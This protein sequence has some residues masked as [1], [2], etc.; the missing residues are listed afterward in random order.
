MNNDP[1]R[2]AGDTWK[3]IP[4]ARRANT[5]AEQED[6]MTALGRP[7]EPEAPTR[8]Y[9]TWRSVGTAAALL[10]VGT[11]VATYRQIERTASVVEVIPPPNGQVY[12]EEAVSSNTRI[13]SFNTHGHAERIVGRYL[14][15][16]EKEHVTV[17]LMQEVKPSDKLSRRN[18]YTV[19]VTA[20]PLQHGGQGIAA[21]VY[22][23]RPTDAKQVVFDGTD[24]VESAIGMLEGAISPIRSTSD[25][26][27]EKR[28]VMAFTIKG[29]FYN[30][31][32]KKFEV[33]DE[34][35]MN[36]QIAGA[37]K[38][39]QDPLRRQVNIA[40][41]AG[42][43][44]VMASNDK[45]GRPTIICGDLNTPP[46]KV[47]TRFSNLG[48]IVPGTR[49]TMVANE[50]EI[51]DYCGYKPEGL[52]GMARVRVVKMRHNGKS[53]SDHNAILFGSDGDQTPI[54]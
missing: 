6:A 18:W 52:L 27:Q 51:N 46:E 12:L 21:M 40:Q 39:G 34:R 25:G 45:D 22:G 37:S 2:E 30:R 10:A 5:S 26:W 20:E 3:L 16:A 28:A 11:A 1:E 15:R 32:K 23:Q 13:M 7:P 38:K 47:I 42:L 29:K 17:A 41:F 31:L 19:P 49:G 8:R 54:E 14:R 44:R 9:I 53:E 48:F 36:T 35:I 33:K 24:F 50:T 43:L 4:E